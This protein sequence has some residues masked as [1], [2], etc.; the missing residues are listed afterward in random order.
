MAEYRLRYTE[1]FLIE[2]FE[3]YMKQRKEHYWLYMPIK[4]IGFLSVAALLILCIYLGL[5]I[6]S[7]I[8]AA[9]LALLV[10]GHRLDHWF[11][12]RRFRRSPFYNNDV[13][14]AVY[15][16]GYTSQSA[17]CTIELSWSTFTKARRFADGFLLF[18]GP[19]QCHWWPDAALSRGNMHAVESIVKAEVADFDIA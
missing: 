8:F 18:N 2:S 11:M 13:L 3:R 4:V 16:D 10:I 19:Q 9:L 12:K 17:N 7:I 1:A 14:V 5:S 15:P 6:P